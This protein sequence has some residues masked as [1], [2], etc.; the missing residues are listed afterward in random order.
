MLLLNPARN[1]FNISLEIANIKCKT[2]AAKSDPANINRNDIWSVL[3]AR[4]SSPVVT[5]TQRA[6][7]RI[8]FTSF[9]SIHS[10]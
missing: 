3:T 8:P 1:T 10:L 7:L 5:I 4:S 2:E 6:S 9:P